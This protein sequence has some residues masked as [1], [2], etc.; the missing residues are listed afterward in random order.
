MV[1]VAKNCEENECNTFRASLLRKNIDIPWVF[2]ILEAR[3]MPCFTPLMTG[4]PKEDQ[5]LSALGSLVR[6]MPRRLLRGVILCLAV[7]FLY[8]GNNP[9]AWVA[10]FALETD[11]SRTMVRPGHFNYAASFTIRLLC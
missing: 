6:S 7:L 11:Q 8:E 10:P 9:S 2:L 4:T 3:V 5:N 1:G